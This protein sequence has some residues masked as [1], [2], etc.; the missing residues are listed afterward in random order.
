[1]PFPSFSR[2]GPKADRDGK[3]QPPKQLAKKGI[4][5]YI[6]KK[7]LEGDGGRLKFRPQDARRGGGASKDDGEQEQKQKQK[8]EQEQEQEGQQKQERAGQGSELEVEIHSYG[9]MSRGQRKEMLDLV[10]GN[11]KAMYVPLALFFFPS[12]KTNLST[13]FLYISLSLSHL[14]LFY[15]RHTSHTINI[16]IYI[17]TV[18]TLFS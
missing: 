17:S 4:P 1:M 11:M 14:F 8:Q 16:C 2:A 15:I 10:E 6:L 3:I 5:L 12:P 9:T 7:S 18:A 13:H